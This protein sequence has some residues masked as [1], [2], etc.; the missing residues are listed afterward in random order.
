ME[1]RWRKEMLPCQ[2]LRY[3][4]KTDR[5]LMNSFS[6]CLNESLQDYLNSFKY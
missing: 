2:H 4:S 5:G 1:N 6:T 3:N